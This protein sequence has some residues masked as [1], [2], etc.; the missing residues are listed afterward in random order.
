[1]RKIALLLL[2]A[3]LLSLCA[4]GEP[5]KLEWM[6]FDGDP[7]SY[8]YYHET[9]RERKWEEDILAL[10]Q[11]FSDNYPIFQQG[12]SHMYYYAIQGIDTTIGYLYDG[13]LRSKFF[14]DVNALIPKLKELTDSQIRFELQKLVA[15]LGDAHTRLWVETSYVLPVVAEPFYVDEEVEYRV[16]VL[17][18][19]FGSMLYSKLLA[20]NGVTIDQVI[21]RLKPYASVE[22]TYGLVAEMSEMGGLLCES[23]LLAHVGI[24]ESPQQSAKLTMQAGNGEIYTISV[25]PVSPTEMGELANESIFVACS[26]SFQNWYEENYWYEIQPEEGIAFVRINRFM[27]EN[28]ESLKQMFESLMADMKSNPQVSRVIVDLRRNGGGQ[29]FMTGYPRLLQALKLPQIEKVSVLI[30]Q[31]SFSQSVIMAY[32][33]RREISTAVVMGIPA[34]EGSFLIGIEGDESTLPNSGLMYRVATVPVDLDR[35]LP[36]DALTPDVI[37]YPTLEDYKAGVDTILEA[38]KSKE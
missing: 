10:A 30:D 1:M 32:E 25:A 36:F 35:K 6:P 5:V 3:L 15:S 13:Q 27:E 18:R 9:E 21:E 14:E 38:A 7:E 24:L 33:I 4:C 37:V 17:P 34:G 12:K 8:S 16:V 23:E 20:I 2:F 28:D 19:A 22:N 11:N 31:G 26:Y 29:S